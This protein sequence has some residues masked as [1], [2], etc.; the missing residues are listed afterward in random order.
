M[1]IATFELLNYTQNFKDITFII[2][3]SLNSGFSYYLLPIN[4]KIIKLLEKEDNNLPIIFYGNKNDAWKI[5]QFHPIGFL[6]EPIIES[7]LLKIIS[8]NRTYTIIKNENGLNIIP[9][10]KIN[11]V[12][13]ENRCLQFYLINNEVIRSF[14]IQKS[15][16]KMTID[17]INRNEFIFLQPT[18]LINKNHIKIIQKDNIIF[19]NNNIC[20]FPKNKYD[21]LINQF[22]VAK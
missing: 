16:A 2:V 4:D 17:I 15:F 12:C 21:E 7:E 9:F 6:E 22:K 3:D 10:N 14:T 19:E 18:L 13:L 1:K 5:C 8:K 11:Y 20:Y